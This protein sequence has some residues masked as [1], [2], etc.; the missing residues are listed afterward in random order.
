MSMLFNLAMR[1]ADAFKPKTQSISR[2]STSL[3]TGS[4][5]FTEGTYE[6]K[7][8]YGSSEKK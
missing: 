3:G 1:D 6:V 4:R 8:L 5:A 2:I 7:R